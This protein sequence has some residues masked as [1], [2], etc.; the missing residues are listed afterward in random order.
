[1][2]AFAHRFYIIRALFPLVKQKNDFLKK[3]KKKSKKGVDKDIGRVY[4]T[5]RD[6][7]KAS[8]N[9]RFEDASLLSRT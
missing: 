8:L 6:E 2:N 9:R 1:M 3:I 7:A 4:N 5:P